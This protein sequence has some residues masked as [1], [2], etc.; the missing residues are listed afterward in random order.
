MSGRFDGVGWP[1]GCR[2]QVAVEAFSW[3]PVSRALPGFR[4]GAGWCGVAW[5]AW[6]GCLDSGEV[7]LRR[8]GFRLL[9]LRVACG[10]ESP[11]AGLS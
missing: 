4:G 9:A 7:R 8:P 10:A 11:R 5:P 2:R 3:L 6:L 1:V